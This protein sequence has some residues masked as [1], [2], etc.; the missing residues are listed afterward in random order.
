MENRK[1]S[2][3]AGLLDSHAPHNGRTIWL[4]TIGHEFFTQWATN[5]GGGNGV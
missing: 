4:N 2:S 5:S 1:P 3:D